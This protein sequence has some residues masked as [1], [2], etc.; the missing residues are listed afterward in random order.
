[1]KY[2]EHSFYSLLDTEYARVVYSEWGPSDGDPVVCVHGLTGNGQ[3]FDYL[4]ESLSNE[5]YRVLCLDLPGRHRS[6]YLKN[7]EGYAY[8]FYVQILNDLL[9]HAGIDK[10]KSVNW[11]GTS[12]G[13]L[14][15]MR[16]G[17]IYNS[18]IKS[19]V[20][21]DIGPHVP[22]AD[23]KLIDTY[24]QQ[25][26]EY[27]SIEALRN[28]IKDLRSPYCGPMTE[29]MWDKVASYSHRQL[30]NGKYT[31]A[32]D[33]EIKYIF[34]KEPTGE[35]PLW[36]Y[37]KNIECP[38]LI[39]R[40]GKSNIFPQHVADRMMAEGPSLKKLTTFVR[41]DDCGHVPSLMDPEQIKTVQEWMAKE[42][43]PAPK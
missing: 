27:D 32:Y 19:L 22:E 1:M 29:E 7:P 23:L 16:M 43:A 8:F 37:W 9:I 40:G 34:E 35:Y 30:P 11:I 18:P 28:K 13:G 14:L 26:Y 21:N 4:A 41:W 24:L 6:D 5:G 33:P 10:P 2:K 17:G 15:G 3:E 12:L 36:M 25:T 20:L 38:V 39:I 31:Y 42:V